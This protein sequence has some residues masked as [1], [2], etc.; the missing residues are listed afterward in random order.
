MVKLVVYYIIRFNKIEI[1]K[2][3]S[4]KISECHWRGKQMK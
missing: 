1:N 3:D 4:D 2:M